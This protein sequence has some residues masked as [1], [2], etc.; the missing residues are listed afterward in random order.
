VTCW[1]CVVQE[2]GKENNA[3]KE[4]PHRILPAR[5]VLS[6]AGQQAVLQPVSLVRAFQLGIELEPLEEAGSPRSPA[7]RALFFGVS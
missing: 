2:D 4:A 3:P 6:E 1:S 7:Q 5:S